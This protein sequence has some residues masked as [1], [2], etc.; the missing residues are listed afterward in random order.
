MGCVSK[1]CDSSNWSEVEG[2]LHAISYCLKKF[3]NIVA[4]SPLVEV[5]TVVGGV[6]TVLKSQYLGARY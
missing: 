3:K 6:S 1:L 4:F 5:R 2:V